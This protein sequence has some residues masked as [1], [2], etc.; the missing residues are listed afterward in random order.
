MSKTTEEI[1]AA[2]HTIAPYLP[3][4]FDEDVNIVLA[5]REQHLLFLQNP[6]LPSPNKVGDPIL[7]GTSIYEALQQEKAV[8]LKIGKDIFGFA[9]RGTG[10]PLKDG[11]GNVIGA[12][13]IARS[14]KQQDQISEISQNV[15]AALQQISAGIST[16]TTG[17]QDTAGM[18]KSILE[19]IGM[20][21]SETKNS[22]SILNVIQNIASQTNLLG[23]NA[24]IEA[25]RAGEQGRGFSVVAEEIRKLSVSSTASIKQVGETIKKIQDHVQEVAAEIANENITFQEQAAALQQITAS[26]EELSA[27]AAI[28]EKIAQNY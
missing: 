13:G 4:F 14:L 24:A 16:I 2:F 23:L 18:S 21:H 8:T 3:S 7:K 22:D 17:V 20:T 28:L 11:D 27:T 25:A 26:I 5:D 15:S 19:K 12:I 6:N 10:I 1:F 9:V